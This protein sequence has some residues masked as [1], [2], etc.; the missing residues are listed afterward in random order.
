MMINPARLN[1]Q[2]GMHQTGQVVLAEVLVWLNLL[3]LL[4][5]DQVDHKDQDFSLK[6]LEF[7]LGGGFALSPPEFFSFFI[8]FIYLSGLSGLSGRKAEKSTT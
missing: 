5:K 2:R 8:L 7:F 1:A 4:P 3:R 6:T